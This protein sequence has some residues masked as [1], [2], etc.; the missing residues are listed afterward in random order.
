[1]AYGGSIQGKMSDESF[2][3]ICTT[4]DKS[5][6]KIVEAVRYCIECSGYCC[7]S[8]TDTHNVFPALKNHNLLDVSQGA[9]AGSKQSGVREFPT[10]RCS[11]HQGKVLDMYC[12]VHDNVVC[13]NCIATSHKSC[14]ETSI[15]SIPDMV[16]TLFTLDDTK[17]ISRHLKDM[18]VSLTTISNSKDRKLEALTKAKLEAIEKV[19]IFE[20]ALKSIIRKAAKGSKSE[21]VATYQELENEILQEKSNVDSAQDELQQIEVKL[22]K[23]EANR[24]QR[25]V[26]TKQAEKKVTE[27]DRL[28][29]KHDMRSNQDA[30]LLFTPNQSLM[31][32]VKGLHG[33]GQVNASR[34]K[35]D[36]YRIKGK[37]DIKINISDDSKTCD[38]F[39]CCLTHDNK[40]LVTD[41]G[42]KKL[43]R[44]NLDTMTVLDSCK[45]DSSPYGVCI[46]SDEE[47]AVACYCPGGIQFVSIQQNMIPTRLIELSHECYG[48]TT[49]HDKLYV[50]DACSSL[51]IY[52]MA[53]TLLKR[54]TCDNAGT[55]LFSYN[56]H[57]TFNEKR[58]KLFVCDTT[59][60]LVCFDGT[61]KYLS[62]SSDSD[63]KRAIGVCV[64]GHGN[65]FA[66]G[67]Y[68]NNVVQF[69]EDGKKI[70]VIVQQ[71]D[72]LVR[73]LSACFHQELNR[74]FVT[75]H[76]NNVL[77]MYELE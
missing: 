8:C 63:L 73:P 5:Y 70:G 28:K 2:D 1:M 40:L 41:S 54:I 6:N 77:K 55:D 35:I 30:T 34:K 49:K 36:K 27:A 52:N 32:Y 62:T 56:R 19:E 39:G 21:I 47:A 65:V 18:M 38:S 22:N 67:F 46:I 7:Q 53:G 44:I 31:N 66:T 43:K 57:V 59:K 29:V 23:S 17:R 15:F 11:L 33:I 45:F 20:K 14:P 50:T 75:M 16:G 69:N 24:A 26:C 58:D 25:F 9:Q 13:S 61:D 4:C 10:E 37:R 48:I 51:Y 71:Q 72:G 3:F 64:D 68:S 76:D 74:L 12:K 42:N 60:G